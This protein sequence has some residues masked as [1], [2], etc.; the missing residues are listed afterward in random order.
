MHLKYT[1]T[2]LLV[3]KFKECFFFYR[4]VLGFEPRAGD[5]RGP[6]AEFKTGVVMVSLFVRQFMA[7]ATGT[8]AKSP[9]AE[10]QDRAVLTFQVHDVDEAFEE[11]RQ[12]GVKFVTEPVDRRDWLIRTAHFRDPDGNLLEINSPLDDSP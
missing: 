12:K 6:Y 2:R 7:H 9:S 3:N 10:G 1:H 5:E 11:L 8:E 4:D